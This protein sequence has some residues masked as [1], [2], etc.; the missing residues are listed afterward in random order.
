MRNSTFN[1]IS[2]LQSITLKI[3]YIFLFFFVSAFV[4]AQTPFDPYCST[5]DYSL[6]GIR[7]ITY[8]GFAGIANNSN[9]IFNNSP[10]LEDFISITANVTTESSYIITLQ[11]NTNGT[12]RINYRVYFDWNQNGIL[13]DPGEMYNC[14]QIFNSTGVDSNQITTTIQIPSNALSGLTRMRV[15]GIG[16]FAL[17]EDPCAGGVSGQSE[18]YSV[19]VTQCPQFTWYLDADNDGYGDVNNT[20]LACYNPGGYV[21]NSDDCDDSRAGVYPNASEICW[22]GVLEDCNG[23]ISQGCS[24]LVLNMVT[25]NSTVLPSFA[26]AVSSHTYNYIG[27]SSIKYR[28]YFKNNITNVVEEIITNTRF[29]T[30]PNNLRNYNTTYDIKVSAV[31]NDEI[32]PYA[33]NTITVSSPMIPTIQLTNTSCGIALPYLG[34]ALSCKPALNVLLYTFRLRLTSDNSSSPTYYYSTSSSRFFNMNSFVGNQLQ[35]G[36]S[37]SISVQYSFIDLLSGLPNLSGYGNECVVTTPVFPTIQVS[38]SFCGQTSVALNQSISIDP[39]PGF[40][41]YK[42][43]LNEV[44]NSVLSLVDVIYIPYPNFKL[45]MFTGAQLNKD[46]SIT[47]SINLNGIYGPD[48]SRCNISTTQ[49][50]NRL[51]EQPFGAMI[52]PNPFN[53]SFELKV[54]SSSSMPITID[55][56]NVLGR[57]IINKSISKINEN[58]HMIETADIPSGVYNLIIR[59][60]EDIKTL[61][62]IKR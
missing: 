44:Q 16:N 15:K 52:Y 26:I 23:T 29:A 45:N 54:A 43:T 9:P 19:L 36:E 46:Y 10:A 4:S 17:N 60:G 11:S 5:I 42:V 53:S 18:D 47:V 20:I 7:P 35:Y 14:G 34:Y 32:I 25:P 56:Y 30:I 58:S 37:Y 1:L 38:G 39:Y 24:P 59:Q 33:G 21:L 49:I 6:F 40:P 8:V 41:M 57:L 12:S 2:K 22:N 48:G 13:N 61:R 62:I 51:N 28:F 3:F 27:A 50:Q 55:L 31:V